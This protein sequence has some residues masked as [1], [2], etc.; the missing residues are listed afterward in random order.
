[1]LLRQSLAHMLMEEKYWGKL[2]HWLFIL[3]CFR[4]R[5]L[6]KCMTAVSSTYFHQ[7]L[8]WLERYVD[9]IDL[10][11]L[12]EMFLRI[13]YLLLLTKVL[14][15]MFIWKLLFD[16]VDCSFP[17]DLSR[18]CLKF[19]REWPKISFW[20]LPINSQWAVK[21]LRLTYFLSISENQTVNSKSN[22]C[23]TIL[24]NLCIHLFR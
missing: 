15:C 20:T 2:Q 17:K 8:S 22:I 19:G 18:N 4:L 13:F 6:M 23:G 21:A 1:M 3:H 5:I 24:Y 7:C 16:G 10:G 11:I 12:L 9:I 14:S